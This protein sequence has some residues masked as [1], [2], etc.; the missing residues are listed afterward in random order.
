MIAAVFLISDL[1]YKVEENACVVCGERRI[2][3]FCP[4]FVADYDT[5][6]GYFDG[7]LGV[8]FKCVLSFFTRNV[9]KYSNTP[10]AFRSRQSLIYVNAENELMREADIRCGWVKPKGNT[11][12]S[13]SFWGT[14]DVW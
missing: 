9:T 11:G 8:E 5:D 14:R 6:D 4:F 12:F 3:K 7:I 2:W 1:L 10:T 13:F